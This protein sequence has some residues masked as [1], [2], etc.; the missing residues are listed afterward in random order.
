[1]EANLFIVCAGLVSNK[2]LPKDFVGKKSITGVKGISLTYPSGSHPPS[3][4]VTDTAGKFVVA[5]L[6]KQ[7]RVA[8]YA[9]FSDNL[10]INQ[11]H[12]ALLAS[13]AKSLMPNAA[14]FD[15]KPEVWTGL[16][17]QTPDDLP[18]I[19]KAGAENLFVNAGH[20]SN[21][22]LLAFGSAEKLLEKINE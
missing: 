2:L 17:P 7:I 18:M 8:G 20:G 11:K 14:L 4:S 13:K 12:V 16:R 19:G 10:S 1:M 3:L 5:R 21:G 6:G 9:I 22:W 15:A